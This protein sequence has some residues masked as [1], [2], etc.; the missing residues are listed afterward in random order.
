MKRSQKYKIVFHKKDN[1]TFNQFSEISLS[2]SSTLTFQ[3][4][5]KNIQTQQLGLSSG[6]DPLRTNGNRASSHI[7]FKKIWEKESRKDEIHQLKKTH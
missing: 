6:Q 3:P 7:F 5:G 4:E 2:A 1:S